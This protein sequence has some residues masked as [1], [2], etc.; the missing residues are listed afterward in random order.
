MQFSH[1]PSLD[2]PTRALVE[3][4]CGLVEVGLERELFRR[5]AN[6]DRDAFYEQA[7]HDP[8][9][10]LYN[11]QYLD[12]AAKRACALDDRSLKPGVAVLMV[13]LDHFKAVNDRFGHA[14]GD[15]V[16]NRSHNR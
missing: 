16:L 2:E 12:D 10:G 8:L 4:I 6:I 14:V 9:T 5:A 3:E 11:R 15:Q 7:I 1:T 13:D